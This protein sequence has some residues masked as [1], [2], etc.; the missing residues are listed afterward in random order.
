MLLQRFSIYVSGEA[1]K[2]SVSV[3][4]WGGNLLPQRDRAQW[5]CFFKGSGWG[6]D[7]YFPL[8]DP[9]DWAFSS[10]NLSGVWGGVVWPHRGPSVLGATG[11]WS[12]GHWVMVWS[13]LQQWLW[14]L[15]PL[16]TVSSGAGEG[17]VLGMVAPRFV[18]IELKEERFETKL[19]RFLK[20]R[21][22]TR[23]MSIAVSFFVLLKA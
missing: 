5:L 2:G 7:I 13:L 19:T 10:I 12:G 6:R 1:L 8:L 3:C 16:C 20:E 23:K 14:I 11:S 15:Q 9:L 21:L 17:S 18:T 4:M 22:W